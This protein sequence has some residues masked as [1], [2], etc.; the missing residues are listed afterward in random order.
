MAA[1]DHI[2]V[3]RRRFHIF[4]YWHHGIDIGDGTVIHLTAEPSK[5][6][7]TVQSTSLEDFLKGGDKVVVDYSGFVT[8]LIMHYDMDPP[9]VRLRDVT[10]PRFTALEISPPGPSLRYDFASPSE[11][12]SWAVA[13]T[14]PRAPTFTAS[15]IK[16]IEERINDRERAVAEARKHLGEKG[17]HLEVRNCEHFITFCKSGRRESFQVMELMWGLAPAGSLERGRAVAE[18]TRLIK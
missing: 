4:R 5:K 8:S 1:G 10:T 3:L 12:R 2:A 18:A 7:A 15:T 11:Q 17:Y 16:A 6:D 9:H 13:R 14:L